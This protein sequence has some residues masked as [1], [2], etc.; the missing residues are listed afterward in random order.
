MPGGIPLATCTL[1]VGMFYLH[2]YRARAPA[3]GP[4]VGIPVLS[5]V[6]SFVFY[7]VHAAVRPVR[8]Y[9]RVQEFRRDTR[10]ATRDCWQLGAA[11][12]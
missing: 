10:Y 4:G 11:A 2:S 7:D 6:R 5:V 9:A 3:T 8:F 1:P 12:S